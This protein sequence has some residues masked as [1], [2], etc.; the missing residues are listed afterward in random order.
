MTERYKDSTLSPEERA[1]NLLG[2]LSLD[3]KMAQVN[4]YLWQHGDEE[5]ALRHGIGHV[6]TLE[7]RDVR[8]LE[9]A[10]AAIADIQ[11]K[12]MANSAHHIPA[13]FHMEGLCGALIQEATS[14]PSGI[15]RASSWDAGLEERIGGIVGRQER[16][17]GITQTLAPVLDISRDSRVGR[18]CETYG[19]DP[20]LA[21][22]L[23][24]AYTRGVQG[25][26]CGRQ[27]DAAAKHFLGFHHSLGGIIG[28]DM[29]T[30]E[31]QLREVYAK[32]FQA[33]VTESRLRGI[34]PCYNSVN[35]KPASASKSLLT[36][37]LREEMGFDGVAV[38]DY[39]AVSNVHCLQ[40]LYE[41]ARETGLACMEAGMVLILCD[42]L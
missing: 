40:R 32:P 42:M 25:Q 28:A 29:E 35:G 27:T 17:V 7:I 14:F 23:G 20:A 18:Q 12:V 16:A 2:R 34:M 24:A 9:E 5:A 37:L 6:S 41:T 19:E 26:S 3:E 10:V 22:A 30:G 31:R 11:A 4:C 36:G 38:S 15:G 1:D 13:I 8:T 39:S 21:A 33:A